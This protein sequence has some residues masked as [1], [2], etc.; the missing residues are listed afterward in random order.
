MIRRTTALLSA[1]LLPSLAR[2]QDPFSLSAE[3][4]SGPPQQVTVSGSSMIDLVEGVIR[5]QDQFAPFQGQGVNAA[6]SYGRMADAIQFQRNAAGTSA[7]V[8]IPSTGFTRTFTGGSEQEVLDQIEDFLLKEGADEYARFLREVNE[9]S[10]I[11]VVDGNPQAA[12]AQLSNS[13]FFKFGLHRSPLTGSGQ[14]KSSPYGP[15]LRLDVNGG[16]TSTDE[17]DGLYVTGSLSSVIRI[18]PRIGLAFSSPFMYRK[19][20]DAEVYMGGMEVALPVVLFKAPVG[21]GP[22]WQVTPH[23]VGA[24]A[25]SVDLA[26]GGLFF[27]YGGTSSLAIPVGKSTTLAMGNGIYFYEGQPLNFGDYE[28]D[29]DLSQQ[30]MKHGVKLTRAIGPLS[31]D[32]GLTYTDFLQDSAVD[33]YWSPTVGAV[34]G[35]GT[36]GVRASYQGDFADGYE[37]HGGNVTV[38]LNY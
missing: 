3:S 5:S 21:R 36:L 28:F 22:V 30:V 32:V 8:T 29:T 15:G 9:Q 26:A 35:L 19:V 6:L 1:V 16:F 25:G 11:A 23:V 34:L 27:G 2:A 37:A 4:T 24:A 38:Y 18:I 17:A 7:T 12:T 14:A 31:I 10:L 13:A 33:Q 20:G